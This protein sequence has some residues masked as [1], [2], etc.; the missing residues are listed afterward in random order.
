[1][2]SCIILCGGRSRRMGQDKGLMV[3]DG[4]PMIIHTL[5]TVEEIVDEIILVLRDKKQLDLYEKCVNDIKTQN[6][7]LN[8]EIRLVTD[9]EIDQGPLFGI[10]TGLS[11]IKSEGALVLP[12][13]SPFISSY[14][15]NKIFKLSKESGVQAMVPVW[16]DGLTEPLHAYYLSECIPVI[17]NQ[18][19]KGFRNVKSLLEQINVVYIDVRSLDPEKKSFINLNRPE[20][21]FTSLKK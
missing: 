18:L 12:C 16:P 21:M 13:D 6:P 15:V 17:Q 4:T 9:I 19:K 11:Q 10:Y 7:N 20:D 14:F 5:E 3:L 1:M 2:K 8:T